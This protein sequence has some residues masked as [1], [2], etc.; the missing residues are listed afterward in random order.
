MLLFCN[1]GRC[2]SC[3]QFIKGFVYFQ[4]S[5]EA[6]KPMIKFVGAR[7]PRPDYQQAS[8]SFKRN[9]S[10]TK[11]YDYEFQLPLRFHRK[12]LSIEEIESINV[13]IKTFFVLNVFWAICNFFIS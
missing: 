8:S 13:G 5:S 1:V 2:F 10:A 3:D 9:H 4:L 12:P 11:V 7:L 6:R